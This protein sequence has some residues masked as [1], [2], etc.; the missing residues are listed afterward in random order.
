MNAQDQ[1][2]F[3]RVTATFTEQFGHAPDLVVRAPGR[4]RR[5]IQKKSTSI[6]R[7]LCSYLRC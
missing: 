2:L 7:M 1:A 4:V 5:S 3:D 6:C